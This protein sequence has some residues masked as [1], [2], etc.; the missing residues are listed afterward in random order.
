MGI[1]T[2]AAVTLSILALLP[3]VD[4]PPESGAEARALGPG[5]VRLTVVYD[6][7]GSAPG[8]VGDWGFSCLVEREGRRILFDTGRSPVTLMA[9]L[10]ALGFSPEAL[11]AVVI[12]HAHADHIGGLAALRSQVPGLRVYVPFAPDAAAT[13]GIPGG[14]LVRIEQATLVA[15]GVVVTR[16]L[17]AGAGLVEMAAVVTTQQGLAVITGCAHPGIVDMVVEARRAADERGLHAREVS[18]VMGGFHLRDL[19]ADRL[20]T[21]VRDLQKLGVQRVAPSHCTGEAA[22]SALAAAFG[23]RLLKSGLGSIMTIGAPS[24]SASRAAQGR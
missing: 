7:V 21:V 2:S 1:G 23:P 5:R 12:S 15:P 4:P 20:G 14:E 9:N 3:G 11:D 13:Q 10:R 17:P 24:A 16:P 18:L 22:L 19:T 8:T 6:N